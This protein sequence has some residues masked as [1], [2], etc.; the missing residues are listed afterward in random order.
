MRILHILND[1]RNLGNG[2][3][4]HVVDLSIEEQALGHQVTILSSGGE[5]EA[6]LAQQG[7]TLSPLVMNRSLWLNPGRVRRALQQVS[8]QI[9]DFDLVHCHM[10]SGLLLAYPAC[11]WHGIPLI[12][13][14]HN[15]WQTHARLMGL[16]HQIIAVSQAV[17]REVQTWGVASDRVAVVKNGTVGTLRYRSTPAAGT[18]ARPPGVRR[19]LTIAGLFER[20]GIHILL[21]A[22]PRVIARIP[23]AQF[24]LAGDGP[25]RLRFEAMVRDLGIGRWVSFWGFQPRVDQ[26]LLTVDLLVHPAL[27]EPFG[28]VLTETMAA[29]VP[30][31]ATAVDGIPEV[32]AGGKA[33]LLVP[34][35]DPKALAEGILTLLGNPALCTEFSQ[36][37]RAEALH[38]ATG[39]MAAETLTVY[40]RALAR[41]KRPLKVAG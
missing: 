9:R 12:A 41:A 17:A 31:V 33:G 13:T 21:E 3:V 16:A 29:G 25:D 38:Y 4:N 11:R 18:P 14:V 1:L 27:Q 10:V 35:R 30:I 39:R 37:G 36:R 24:C 23:Q 7:A 20:K 2:I 6:L 26:L 22:V 28:L 5:Y 8:R 34:P 19:V 32:L 40:E 15:S